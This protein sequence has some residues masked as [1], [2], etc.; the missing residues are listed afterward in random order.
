[1]MKH[2]D[3]VVGNSSSGIIEAPSFR[4]P[5]IN[6]GNR[7]KGRIRASSI[8]DCE[9]DV[10]SIKKAFNKLWSKSF[11]ETVKNVKNPY[12]KGGSASKV[13]RHLKSCNLEELRYKKFY[14]IK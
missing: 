5:T 14:D 2:S 8:I 6:I 11:I 10:Q 3:A 12:G 4:V 13:L 9:A 1:M 7:Q